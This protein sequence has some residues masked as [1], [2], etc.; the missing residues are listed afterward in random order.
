MKIAALILT[1]LFSILCIIELYFCFKQNNKMRKIFKTFCVF[2]LSIVIILLMPNHPLLYSALLFGA[3]GDLLL[4][5][6]KDY[7]FYL[8]ALS[9]LTGHALFYSEIFVEILSSFIPTYFYIIFFISLMIISLILYKPFTF[10]TKKKL[11]LL[12]GCFYFSILIGALILMITS[13]CYMPT[14]F[15]YFG[16]LGYVLFITSDFILCFAKFNH[17][18]KYRQFIV[19]LTYLLAELFISLGFYLTLGI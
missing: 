18:F 15:M 5:Y 7:L 14:S 6:K 19:M 17:D 4:I 12:S 8:G 1:I 9:F 2:S 11:P 13:V 3:F 10:I 16:I